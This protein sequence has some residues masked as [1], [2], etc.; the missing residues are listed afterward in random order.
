MVSPE[1]PISI[2]AGLI[3]FMSQDMVFWP[4][5]GLFCLFAIFVPIVLV[6][7]LMRLNQKAKTRRERDEYANE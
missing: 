1:I 4:L 7:V 3:D 2:F 5:T 6:I